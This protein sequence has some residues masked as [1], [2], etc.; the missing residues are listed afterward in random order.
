[1]SIKSRYVI[2]FVMIIGMINVR[3]ANDKTLKI[4]TEKIKE[5]EDEAKNK[6]VNAMHRCF[7]YHEK[8]VVGGFGLTGW[9]IGASENDCALIEQYKKELAEIL[10]LSE[11]DGIEKPEK[12]K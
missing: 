12:V 9:L 3:C 6:L 4:A 5:R 7:F 2:P 10:L 1:M 11:R 8:G